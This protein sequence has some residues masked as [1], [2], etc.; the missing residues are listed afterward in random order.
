MPR[1]RVVADT[2]RAEM[3]VRSGRFELADRMIEL[4]SASRIAD[5]GETSWAWR[6]ECDLLLVGAQVKLAQRQ[7]LSALA[8]IERARLRASQAGSGYHGLKCAILACIASWSLGEHDMALAHLQSAIAAGRAHGTIQP[9]LDE[10]APLQAVIRSIVRR[11]GLSSFSPDAV[12]FLGSIAGLAA[13]RG[14]ARDGEPSRRRSA[15]PHAQLFSQREWEV[16][17][18]LQRGSSNKE[19]ARELALAETTV[20]FHLKN[21]FSKLG[22]SRR[23][24]AVVVAKRI[25][26][27]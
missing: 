25:A 16:L 19:I 14:P 1:L 11:F 2:L 24:L 9:F 3:L 15:G 10:G 17:V 21:I 23:G 4:L 7:H 8:D 26:A 20:K 5:R 22:V 6:E 27:Q 12:G 18:Q 13:R